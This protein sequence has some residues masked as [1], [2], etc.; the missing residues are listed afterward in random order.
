MVPRSGYEGGR[1]CRS[2][3]GKGRRDVRGGAAPER[4]QEQNSYC[5]GSPAVDGERVYVCF[6][7]AG[8]FAYDLDGREVWRRDL[9]KLDHLFGNAVSPILHADLCM[10]NYGPGA[11]ARLVALD[12]KTGQ[13][14]WEAPLPWADPGERDE[15][16]IDA[17]GGESGERVAGA[18]TALRDGG[19]NTEGSWSTPVVIST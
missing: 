4:T 15:T 19:D 13:T 12:R 2:R 14:V 17:A 5:S 10:L 11:N 7:S 8:V 6:G 9:G 1:R 18:G 16:I 3:Q